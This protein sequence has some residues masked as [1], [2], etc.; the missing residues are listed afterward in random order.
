MSLI[1]HNRPLKKMVER[2]RI[3]IV[4]RQSL[5]GFIN[6]LINKNVILRKFA[7]FTNKTIK[8][9][10]E[11]HIP[12]V[13]PIPRPVKSNFEK[14]NLKSEGTRI[15]QI[16]LSDL[17]DYEKYTFTKKS[18]PTAP[19]H[20]NE[21][22]SKLLNV[23]QFLYENGG[24]YLNKPIH[25]HPCIFIKNHEFIAVNNDLFSCEKES[26]TIKKILDDAT[27]IA[28]ENGTLTD[29]IASFYK[30]IEGSYKFNKSI[31]FLI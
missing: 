24:I 18:I 7:H 16:I 14:I 13:P 6:K 3:E 1:V 29:I 15:P 5:F 17:L 11:I 4:Q 21:E 10:K 31:Q 22:I 9:H 28:S 8:P 12:H 20:E 26:P 27:C 25:T 23:Y 30:N 2:R 19:L